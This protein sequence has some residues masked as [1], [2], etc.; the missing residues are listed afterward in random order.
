MK[1]IVVKSTGSWVTVRQEDGQ[2]TGCTLKGK[3]RMEGIKSTNPVAVGDRVEFELLPDEDTGVITSILERSNYLIR[4]ATKLS[5]VS[6]I[7]AANIDQ[8]ILVAT[9]KKPRTPFGFID[10]FLVTAEAYHIPGVIAF[11]KMDLYD[12]VLMDRLEELTNI[13]QEAEYK[14]LNVSAVSGEGLDELKAVMKDKTSLLAGHSGVGKSSLINRLQPGLNIKTKEISTY[15]EKGQHV[16]TFAQMYH[17]N[18][19]GFIIDTPGI[20]EFGLI[21]FNKEEVAERFPELRRYMH[22]CRYNNCTH[23]HEPGCA[24]KKAL[25]EGLISHKRY[26]SYLRIYNDDDWYK[27]DWG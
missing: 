10:R 15:N 27:K 18:F 17:L 22:Q 2:E 26:N 25:E 12:D 14:C 1:G 23:T 8:A 5:K 3:F 7:I 4:K 13:Y 21:D 9:L 16:T 11:N 20:R 24:V 6:Q 19:G